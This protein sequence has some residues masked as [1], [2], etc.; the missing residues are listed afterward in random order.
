MRS[1]DIVLSL[2][3]AALFEA[4][5]QLLPP[6]TAAMVDLIPS[7]AA[8]ISQAVTCPVG[9]TTPVLITR[10][11]VG[12]LP[13]WQP[14]GDLKRRYHGVPTNLPVEAGS[15]EESGQGLEFHVHCLRLTADQERDPLD[16]S[17]SAVSWKVQGRFG[18]L[19]NGVSATSTWLQ[20]RRAYTG[21]VAVSAP[22]V[23]FVTFCSSPDFGFELED[24]GDD[25]Y[26]TQDEK[27]ISTKAMTGAV[28]ILKERVRC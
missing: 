27:A 22:G 1:S 28:V 8:S 7:P 15:G 25:V 11:S 10:D 23:V 2:L 4:P 16:L 6:S 24:A 21:P 26:M 5:S 12:G 17:S 14:L 13:L 3:I 19:P 9:D 18:F 20:L